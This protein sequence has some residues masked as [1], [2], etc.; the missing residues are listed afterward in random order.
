MKNTHQAFEKAIYKS[1]SALLGNNIKPSLISSE[2]RIR[3]YKDNVILTLTDTL[4]NRHMAVL[5]LVGEDFFKYMA[6]E[7]IK[8][9]PSK[10]GNLDEY[11][12]NFYEFIASFQPAANLPYLPDV[13]HLEWLMHLAYFASDCGAIDKTKLSQVPPEKIDQIKFEIHPSANFISS[14]YPI[15]NIYNFSLGKLDGEI[16]I[17]ERGAKILVYRYEYE[18][19]FLS[20]TD[21][22]YSFLIAINNNNNLYQAFENT[23]NI[24]IG[25]AINKFVNNGVFVEF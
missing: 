20:L 6:N 11:G 25:S 22:E 3:I 10:S 21:D 15:D 23:A 2:E 18:V 7:F 19:K 17:N 4:K 1:D 5:N 24:D 8:Q 13:A 12:A 9:N 14:K 16:N